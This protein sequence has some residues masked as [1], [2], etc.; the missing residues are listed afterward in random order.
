V[1]PIAIEAE[2]VKRT[3]ATNREIY[4][5]RSGEFSE[6]HSAALALTKLKGLVYLV[7]TAAKDAFS[8]AEQ[9]VGEATSI[10][11]S[12]VWSQEEKGRRMTELAEKVSRDARA[13]LEAW[14]T[15]LAGLIVL[16]TK[17]ALPKLPAGADQALLRQEAE[18][19]LTVGDPQQA[20][21][22]L[23]RSERRDLAAIA[24]SP[25]AATWAGVHGLKPDDLAQVRL[26]AVQVAKDLGSDTER[27]AAAM[28][29]DVLKI[30]GLRGCVVL[31][32]KAA[33]DLLGP[34]MAFNTAYVPGEIDIVAWQ[35]VGP[36]DSPALT[37]VAACGLEGRPARQ[38]GPVGP[39]PADGPGASFRWNGRGAASVLA[40]NRYSP[41]ITGDAE[42]PRS[43]HDPCLSA[44][45]ATLVSRWQRA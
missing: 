34:G 28:Y 24:L 30:F 25:W 35:R 21:L 18:L 29:E 2:N 9:L 27:A 36:Q 1:D 5:K 41:I 4:A 40:S 16:T 14:D 10:S 44:Q 3:I 19:V 13:K 23:V 6:R 31:S 42:R 12:P 15:E 39:P 38:V 7:E 20:L 33:A 43:H 22:S 37:S 32:L 45:H 26:V 8:Y 17:D 11:Q